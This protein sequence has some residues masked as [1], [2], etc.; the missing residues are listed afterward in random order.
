MQS[1]WIEL[2]RS[3][4][5]D[6]FRQSHKIERGRF[7]RYRTN[8]TYQTDLSSIL[9]GKW[10]RTKS[11][12]PKWYVR[13]RLGKTCSEYKIINFKWSFGNIT[14]KL[15]ILYVLV[16]KKIKRQLRHFHLRLCSEMI[17]LK[18][19]TTPVCCCFSPFIFANKKG[20]QHQLR[21]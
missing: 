21:M 11:S 2:H 20:V 12:K 5:F 18:S 3:I 19:H 4:E 10:N 16:A 7:V 1:N 9:F 6:W 8:R 13:S 14:A 15:L 17:M